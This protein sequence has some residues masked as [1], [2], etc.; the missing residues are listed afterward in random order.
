M[1]GGG[2]SNA[3][4]TTYGLDDEQRVTI[5]KGVRL[6]EAVIHRM[7]DGGDHSPRTPPGKGATPAADS[8]SAGRDAQGRAEADWQQTRARAEAEARSRRMELE[9]AQRDAAVAGA[10][11]GAAA[12]GVGAGGDAAL[13]QAVLRE[14]LVVEEDRRKL[15][16]AAR[17]VEEKEQEVMR[18]QAKYR[19]QIVDLNSKSA[20]FYKLSS[21]NFNLTAQ[22]AEKKLPKGPYVPVCGDLQGVVLSCYNNSGG[23]TLNCSAVAKQYMQCVNSAKQ[24]LGKA[25]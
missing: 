4:R 2:S 18:L 20:T 3:R 22:E 21:D 19:Q 12:A 15:K 25:S 7:R 11:A 8:G 5:V 24:L 17:H 14:R 6:S 10:A 16:M 9:R 13:T 1:G 23:Q